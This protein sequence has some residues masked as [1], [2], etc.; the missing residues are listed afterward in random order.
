MGMC[1]VEGMIKPN[2]QLWPNMQNFVSGL[3]GFLNLG[4]CISIGL[5]AEINFHYNTFQW[6]LI[7]QCP[8][9]NSLSGPSPYTPYGL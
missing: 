5:R 7:I 1:C 4:L 2:D 9:L 3:H 8:E 6:T